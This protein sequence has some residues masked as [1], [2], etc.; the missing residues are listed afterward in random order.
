MKKIIAAF[1]LISVAAV[2][3]FSDVVGE[4]SDFENSLRKGGLSAAEADYQAKKTVPRLSQ[5]LEDKGIVENKEW[6]FPLKDFTKADV[7]NIK[8]VLSSMAENVRD[9]K[10]LDGMEFLVQPNIKLKV[11]FSKER[12]KENKKKDAQS[13]AKNEKNETDVLAANN[14][15]VLYV[16]TGAV[17]SPGG[18]TVWIYNPAQNFFIYYGMLRNIDVK[19]GEIVAAGSKIGSIRGD[20][21]GYELNF[22]VLMYGDETFTLFNYF[23]EMQ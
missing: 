11:V 5:A 19:P 8:K 10:F 22:A 6:I 18:N 1:V 4:W 12:K 23:D 21:N 15:I 17:N 7:K 3:A 2:A 14:G 9:T 16:K 20:K 13:S